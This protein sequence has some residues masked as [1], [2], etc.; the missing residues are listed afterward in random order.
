MAQPARR[1]RHL[2]RHVA[3]DLGQ[4]VRLLAYLDRID[5]RYPHDERAPASSYNVF[6]ERS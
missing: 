4:A 5:V 3:D 6:V 2:S 1:Q